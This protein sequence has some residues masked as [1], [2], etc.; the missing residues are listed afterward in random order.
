[1]ALEGPCKRRFGLTWGSP[2][3]TFRPMK[4]FLGLRGATRPFILLVSLMGFALVGCGD[5]E[6]GGSNTGGTGGSGAEFASCRLCVG[7]TPIGPNES[8]ATCAAFGELFGCATTE[9]VGVCPDEGSCMVSDCTSVP[10]C[11]TELP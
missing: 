8:E 4:S 7:A 1:M 11:N 2:P 5:S 3:L 6:S 9:L 10:D